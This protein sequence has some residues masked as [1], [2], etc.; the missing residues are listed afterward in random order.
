MFLVQTPRA[1]SGAILAMSSGALTPEELE[2][3]LEDAFVVRDHTALAGLF[4]TDALVAA[5][6]AAARGAGIEAFVAALWA[7]EVTYLAQ[8]RWVL[9]AGNTALIVA[10][11]SISVVHRAADARWRYAIAL[12]NPNTQEAMP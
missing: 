6:G 3:L 10:E 7:R 8:P 9:Q 5:A 12:L 11:Q 4:E 2:T 1:P